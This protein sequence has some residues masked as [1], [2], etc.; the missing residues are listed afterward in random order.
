MIRPLPHDVM[1]RK[2]EDVLQMNGMQRE[3]RSETLSL[4][5]LLSVQNPFTVCWHHKKKSVDTGMSKG[6]QCLKR[7]LHFIITSYFSLICYSCGHCFS[8]LQIW[9]HNVTSAHLATTTKRRNIRWS[10][11]Q[12]TVEPDY[13]RHFIWRSNWKKA[14]VLRNEANAVSLYTL[15]NAYFSPSILREDLTNYRNPLFI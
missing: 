2:K 8:S 9:E 13:L 3:E 6:K 14:P 15:M 7:W 1:Q 5:L 10:D 11:Q 4:A 12:E